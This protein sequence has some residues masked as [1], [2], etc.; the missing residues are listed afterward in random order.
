M[1]QPINADEDTVSPSE[2]QPTVSAD[3]PLGGFNHLKTPLRML[4]G[5]LVSPL[6]FLAALLSFLAVLTDF[7]FFRLRNLRDGHPEPKGLWEF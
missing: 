4:V 2:A 6:L 7:A 5:L 1:S 3:D